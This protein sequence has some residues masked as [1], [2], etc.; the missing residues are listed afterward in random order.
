MSIY[1]CSTIQVNYYLGCSVYAFIQ[2]QIS[3]AFI[4]LHNLHDFYAVSHLLLVYRK[5]EQMV[6]HAHQIVWQISRQ[7]EFSTHR[8][9]ELQLSELLQKNLCLVGGIN[10]S[11]VL[12]ARSSE[13]Q[14][15]SL[16]CS[17]WSCVPAESRP[18][19]PGPE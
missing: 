18:D 17:Q 16:S 14:T 15:A 8:K 6:Q 12:I 1:F 9:T 5:T 10:T 11:L 13:D 4:K 7:T 2:G 3:N 19:S